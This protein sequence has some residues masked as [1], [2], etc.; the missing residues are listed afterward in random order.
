MGPEQSQINQW[1]VV[2][3]AVSSLL[4]ADS[5]RISGE[6][7]EHIEALAVTQGQLPPITVHRPTMRVIDGMHRL[8]V[9]KLRGRDRIT[10]RFFDGDETDAFV[11][12]VRSN[13]AHGLPL[14]LADRKAAAARIIESHPQ[15][16]DRMIASVAGLAAR[17]VAEIRKRPTD[18]SAR[19]GSRIGQDGRVRPIDGTPGRVLA[20]ELM[21]DNPSL[22]LRQ[23]ARAAGI[24]PE[25]ARDVRNRLRR[26][27]DPVSKQQVNRDRVKRDRVKREQVD[28]EPVN[29]GPVLKGGRDGRSERPS[30]A[31]FNRALRQN[32]PAVIERLRAD[33]SLR[34]TETGR[35]LLRLLYIHSIN[36]EEWE[37]LIQ[38][39]PPHCSSL[40]AQLARDYAQMWKELA[41][42]VE[43]EVANVCVPLRAKREAAPC[44]Q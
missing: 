4:V 23:V 1:P 6:N 41:E 9:A 14:S 15:W 17:T 12:A 28:R 10:V 20:L 38:N 11:L 22:S 25:T 29:R 30:S 44:L 36:T 43:S 40:V 24:S 3:V 42:R 26:G 7:Q 27:E 5:L 31:G 19:S 33:P 21:T 8:R 2:E 32:R 39:I 16:S 34:L 18:E 37:K 35:T 13:I